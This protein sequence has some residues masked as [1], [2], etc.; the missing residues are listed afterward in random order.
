MKDFV[1]KSDTIGLV[2]VVGSQPAD[3]VQ[4][5]IKKIRDTFGYEA[6]WKVNVTTDGAATIVA[7]RKIHCFPQVGLNTTSLE[8]V[9]TK[10]STWL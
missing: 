8:L 2:R 1:I 5:I 3:I 7:T 4:A 10:Q 6:N 9:L